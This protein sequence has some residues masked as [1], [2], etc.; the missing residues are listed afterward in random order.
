MDILEV[1][2]KAFRPISTLHAAANTG[3]AGFDS[4]GS[5]LRRY[6]IVGGRYSLP[7]D[8]INKYRDEIGKKINVKVVVGTMVA[9]L[10][11]VTLKQRL[12]NLPHEPGNKEL[13]HHG[14]HGTPM[15]CRCGR[16][17]KLASC[18]DPTS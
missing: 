18:V 5:L 16:S 14:V 11:S 12:K 3:S 17:S 8:A 2:F 1:I 10:D 7:D 9:E 13:L 15:R 4:F 6:H